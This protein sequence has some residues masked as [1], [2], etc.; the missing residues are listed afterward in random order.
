[1]VLSPHIPSLATAV[2]KRKVKIKPEQ[3]NDRNLPPLATAIL[4]RK[5]K[6][7]PEQ[8]NDWKGLFINDA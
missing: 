2:L 4:K 1:M 6:I 8:L 7:E 5:V 3:L